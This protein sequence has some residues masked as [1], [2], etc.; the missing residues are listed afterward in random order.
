MRELLTL[1]KGENNV[2][3]NQSI[4]RI[5]SVLKQSARPQLTRAQ[6]CAMQSIDRT[7]YSVPTVCATQKDRSLR[8]GHKG[9]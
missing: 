8:Y 3:I 2:V 9:G 1:E 4:D 6:I 5:G 7:C